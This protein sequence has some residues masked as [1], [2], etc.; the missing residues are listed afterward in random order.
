MKDFISIGPAPCDEDCVQVGDSDYEKKAKEECRRFIE[1]IRKH[2][3]SE[4]D[5]TKAKLSIK[6]FD[7]DFGRY[8]EVVCWY[9]EDNKEAIDYAYKCESNAPSSW[10]D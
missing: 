9:D 1:L 2:L 4:P 7:H 8:Y 6:G 3:G 5:S 10:D